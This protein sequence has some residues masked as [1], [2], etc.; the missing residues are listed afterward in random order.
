MKYGIKGQALHLLMNYNFWNT[1]SS[2]SHSAYDTT[3]FLRFLPKCLAGPWNNKKTMV[4]E[5]ET[6]RRKNGRREEMGD[7]E[8][9]NDI[10]IKLRDVD[11]TALWVRNKVETN[12]CEGAYFIKRKKGKERKRKENLQHG[13]S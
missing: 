10:G 5:R 12:K 8:K 11:N 2:S 4:G 13:T 6:E 3:S 7:K 1:S 9:I